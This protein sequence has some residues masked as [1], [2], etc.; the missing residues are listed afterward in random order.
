MPSAVSLRF[1][2][3]WFPDGTLVLA[4]EV[5]LFHIDS[6]LI[7]RDLPIFHDML[8]LALPKSDKF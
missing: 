2:N 3:L 8:E 5:L 4:T 1:N 7:T 6:R